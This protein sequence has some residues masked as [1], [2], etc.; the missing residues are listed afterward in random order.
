MSTRAVLLEVRREALDAG[1]YAAGE[2]LA[3]DFVDTIKLKKTPTVDLLEGRYESFWR[4]HRA[5][6]LGVQS[7]PPRESALALRAVVRSLFE[8]A[9]DG[10]P[11]DAA[12][13]QA[14]NEAAGSSFT[15]SHMGQNTEGL[16][17]VAKAVGEGDP[18][19]AAVARSAISSLAQHNELR[20]CNSPRC[21]MLY[22][23]RSAAR[24]WCSNSCGNR[25]RVARSLR[26]D[27]NLV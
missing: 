15:Y 19:L 1:F 12:M 9:I 17:F 18:A 27:P 25:M 5:L 24:L 20:R 7:D 21:S 22:V 2:S 10:A 11:L 6:L 4:S 23:S 14:L 13:V 3:V 26:G 16:F 8:S